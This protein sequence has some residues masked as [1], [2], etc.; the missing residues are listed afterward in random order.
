[1]AHDD[2]VT[3]S[4]C[5]C[6]GDPQHSRGRTLKSK[7]P[8]E[9]V[10]EGDKFGQRLAINKLAWLPVV[11]MWLIFVKPQQWQR[12]PLLFL[13]HTRHTHVHTPCMYTVGGQL[14]CCTENICDVLPGGST[15]SISKVL[16]FIFGTSFGLC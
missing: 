5:D 8:A 14:R 11:R 1:M 3:G 2:D 7:Q 9:V 16:Y 15:S 12:S 10:P 13:S 6:A 4:D